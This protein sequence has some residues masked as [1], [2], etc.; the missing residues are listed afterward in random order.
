LGL[1]LPLVVVVSML[2]VFW[3]GAIWEISFRIG[4]F[5]YFIRALLLSYHLYKNIP[6][7]L[8]YLFSYLC[9]AEYAPLLLMAQVLMAA[10]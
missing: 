5:L 1:A 3:E 4:L 9:I 8:F 6:T 2:G 7:Q 10:V